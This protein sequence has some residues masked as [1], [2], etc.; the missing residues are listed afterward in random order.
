M[1]YDLDVNKMQ[2]KIQEVLS[3][4]PELTTRPAFEFGLHTLDLDKTLAD[5]FCEKFNAVRF[6]LELLFCTAWIIFG[7]LIPV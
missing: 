7:L 2:I 4:H 5:Y 1:F 3:Q 6:A